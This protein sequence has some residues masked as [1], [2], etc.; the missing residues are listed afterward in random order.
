MDSAPDPPGG[1]MQRDPLGK[2]TGP[3]LMKPR[4]MAPHAISARGAQ[5]PPTMRANAILRFP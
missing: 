3:L 2:P 5:L 4:A 1:Q